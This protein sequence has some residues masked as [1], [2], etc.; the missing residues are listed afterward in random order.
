MAVSA[1][2]APELAAVIRDLP[3]AVRSRLGLEN[4]EYACSAGA[5]L[6]VCQATGV[7][8]IFD[9]HHH[10]LKEK[11]TS[12]DDP[13]VAAMVQAAC[14]TWPDPSWQLVHLSNGRDRFHDR[15]HSDLIA[16]TRR[17]R[18]CAVD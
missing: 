1:G 8:M 16:T 9:A 6:A 2:A 14:A 7:P 13:S 5:I 4:D 10:L 12:Y 18:H 3:D 11:L 17:L 15:S